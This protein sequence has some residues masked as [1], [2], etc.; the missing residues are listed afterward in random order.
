MVTYEDLFQFCILIVAL[1]GLC[2]KIFKDK[3]K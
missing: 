1:V 2:Y 3:R